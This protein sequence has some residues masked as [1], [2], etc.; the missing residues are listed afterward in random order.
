LS[1]TITATTDASSDRTAPS[2]PTLTSAF[3]GG[4]GQ[5]PEELWFTF[6]ASTDPDDP[7]A[8]LEYEVRVDATIIDVATATTT[9][10]SW[11]SY[12]GIPGVDHLTVVAT[13][14]AGNAS[15]PSNSIPIDVG[16]G[17]NC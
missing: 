16:P 13:D 5:C 1:N 9:T 3:D 10:A 14:P 11:I 2:T 15:A 17:N 12:S 6:T 8:S 4:P 7:P